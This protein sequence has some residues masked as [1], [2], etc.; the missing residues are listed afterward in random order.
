MFDVGSLISSIAG[1]GTKIGTSVAGLKKAKRNDASSRAASNAATKVAKS[2]VGASQTGHGAS[3]GLAL[4]SGLRA[5]T[6][7]AKAASTAGMAANADENRF[8]AQKDARN[9]RLADFGGD[10][11]K[12][13]GDVAGSVIQ[14]KSISDASADTIGAQ[15]EAGG[16]DA[17]GLGA[18][19]GIA[20][21]AGDDE[22]AAQEQQ[23]LI[24]SSAEQ[25]DDFRAKADAAVSGDVDGGPRAAFQVD[26]TTQLIESATPSVQPELEQMLA[27]KFHMKELA[28]AEGER[29]GLSME[30]I[31]PRLNRKLQL[32][33]GQSAKNPMGTFY[34]PEDDGGEQ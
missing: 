15:P 4:R 7:A 17:T 1:I 24:D 9:A 34:E 22:V 6:D 20:P 16:D 8:Q 28:L 5:A 29:L 31:L 21:G 30:E 13:L 26:P 27:D 32:R 3:R 2:A 19:A 14:P 18:A 25:L 10:L 11:A 12:G 23:Q 33:P